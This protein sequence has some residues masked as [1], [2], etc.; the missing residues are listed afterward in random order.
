MFTMANAKT[1]F[2]NFM[3]DFLYLEAPKKSE[4]QVPHHDHDDFYCAECNNSS[5]QFKIHIIHNSPFEGQK[6]SWQTITK[7]QINVNYGLNIQVGIDS[8]NLSTKQLP[9]SK[10]LEIIPCCPF[11]YS[12]NTI[13]S[14]KD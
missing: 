9:N 14:Q 12:E 4:T 11:C 3:R 13:Y 7:E 6:Q 2:I 5:N 10:H 8:L 1:K